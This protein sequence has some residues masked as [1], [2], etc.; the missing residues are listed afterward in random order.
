MIVFI[1][2]NHK[3]FERRRNRYFNELVEIDRPASSRVSGK[4]RLC[5]YTLCRRGLSDS[6]I[7]C[8]ATSLAHKRSCRRSGWTKTW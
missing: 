6:P 7:T 1:R 4:L 5:H 2:I 8:E 3:D